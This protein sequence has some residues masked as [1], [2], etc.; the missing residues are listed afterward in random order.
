MEIVRY[1]KARESLLEGLKGLVEKIDGLDVE[2]PDI[3]VVVSRLLGQ[4]RSA[5]ELAKDRESRELS[6]YEEEVEATHERWSQIINGL[7]E[8]SHRLM[9]FQMRLDHPEGVAWKW[10]VIDK[11]AVPDTYCE[12][13]VDSDAVDLAVKNGISEIPGIKIYPEGEDK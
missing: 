10:R 11:N 2:V 1:E 5:I 3:R 9:L 8:E 6:S 13:W 7:T 4:V 12:R